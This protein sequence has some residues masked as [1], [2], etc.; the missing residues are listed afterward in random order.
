MSPETGQD[1]TAR[2]Q[3]NCCCHAVGMK[4]QHPGRWHAAPQK[5]QARDMLPPHL[6]LTA[7]IERDVGLVGASEERT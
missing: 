7:E 4:L 5:D 2:L 6:Q 3:T 1:C